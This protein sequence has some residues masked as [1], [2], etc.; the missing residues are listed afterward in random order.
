MHENERKLTESPKISLLDKI[1]NSEAAD[2]L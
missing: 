1:N 2:K